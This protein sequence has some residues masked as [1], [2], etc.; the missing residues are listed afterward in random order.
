M[1]ANR[2]LAILIGLISLAGCAAMPSPDSG[3]AALRAFIPEQALVGHFTG[4]GVI[5]P[6][7]GADSS[8]DV[9]INGSWDG[10]VLTLVEDFKYS[11]GI[12]EQKTWRLTKTPA[13]DYS[14][15]REDVIGQAHAYLEGATMRLDY[16]LAIDTPLGS[17]ARFQDVLYWE[18][19]QVIRN[20]ATMSKFGLRLALLSLQL[21][22]SP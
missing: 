11:S 12:A 7:I 8:F 17:T 9:S 13:G 6:I 16:L 10:S 20:K 5:T 15:T 1:T 21:V 14:G 4:H 18:N 3:T 2:S 22:P 19:G